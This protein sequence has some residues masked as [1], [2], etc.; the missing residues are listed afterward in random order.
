[1]NNNFLSLSLGLM[2]IIQPTFRSFAEDTSNTYKQKVCRNNPENERHHRLLEGDTL[3]LIN[4]GED[5][6]LPN[7]GALS[8]NFFMSIFMGQPFTMPESSNKM[9][10]DKSWMNRPK[11]E[12]PLL[13]EIDTSLRP[14]ILGNEVFYDTFAK[15]IK[16]TDIGRDCSISRLTGSKPVVLETEL[17]YDFSVIEKDITLGQPTMD[18]EKSELMGDKAEFILKSKNSENLY[19]LVCDNLN[20]N[21]GEEHTDLP[22]SLYSLSTISFNNNL[23]LNKIL[24]D[25]TTALY[26]NGPDRLICEDETIEVEPVNF[27][28]N[29]NRSDSSDREDGIAL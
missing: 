9:F 13:P 29:E 11:I 5:K 27:E 3:R 20:F 2:L 12:L 18:P 19:Y 8:S 15:S 14:K 16:K 26:N 10:I 7:P 17:P 6:I 24:P 25:G 22:V 28:L 4:K 23:V 21:L 1:M